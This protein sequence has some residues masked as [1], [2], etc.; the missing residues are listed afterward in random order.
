MGKKPID[1]ASRWLHPVRIV[2][3]FAVATLLG[4]CAATID[5]RGHVP[6]EEALA[7][8]RL[9]VDT[10]EDVRQ[11]LG[12]PSTAATFRP[13]VWYY[14]SE[15]TRSVAFLDPK[16]VKRS[17]VAI[18]FD[19]GGAIDDIV[20]YTEAD[21]REIEVVSRAT[22]TAGNEISLFQQL[23]GNLGRFENQ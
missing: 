18:T 6:D 12:S 2:G 23:F 8:L 13:N 11:A 20:T 19:D 9:G 4:A 10:R 22:P 16:V 14:M 21:G 3:I 5:T 1:H 7:G 17:I 15:R